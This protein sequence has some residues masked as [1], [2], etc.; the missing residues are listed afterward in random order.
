[1]T[2]T[3][4]DGPRKVCFMVMPYGKRVTGV[5]AP[6]APKEV[7][8]DRLW[9][10]AYRP[11]LLK[12]GY[13]PVRADMDLGALIIKEMLERFVI[14]H[15]VCADISIPN[16]NVYYEIGVRHAAQEKG[17]VM[18]AADWA[19]P[20]FDIAQ[21]PR[22]VYP[23]ADGSV[24][25]SCVTEVHDL[26]VDHF[27][28]LADGTSP[29]Y[30]AVTGY[31]NAQLDSAEAFKAFVRQL[32]TIQ[33]KMRAIRSAAPTRRAQMALALAETAAKGGE[34]PPSV[35]L[36]LLFLL[37]DVAGWQET[38]KYIEKLP[39]EMRDIPVVLE[40]LALA[41]SKSRSH[42][43]AVSGLETLIQLS[44]ETSERRGLLGGRF[45]KLMQ[46]AESTD[47]RFHYLNRA[48]ENYQ[49]GTNLDLNDYYPSSNLP[50]L[51][52]AWGRDE[53]EKLA[54]AAAT[55]ALAAVHRA[56]AL[57]PDDKWIRPTLLGAAFDDGNVR[58]A[59]KLCSE[60]RREGA[61]KWKLA[62]TLSDLKQAIDL[63]DDE[64]VQG[65]LRGVFDDL[66]RL[67]P[68]K[69]HT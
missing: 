39:A 9:E 54:Q 48:I 44:G 51:Y 5:D 1:M 58:E 28:T 47:D 56:R 22:L 57:H 34:T 69:F 32:S 40:Q 26:I 55:I 60:I 63:L 14:A 10:E 25:D 53:D 19:K 36:E 33:G 45:K 13:E 27:Q 38:K 46:D 66:A 59:K 68:D 61:D 20:L 15:L 62:T 37:R 6:N 42:D 43:E 29:V 7:D 17:C 49:L 35:S 31:P 11:A 50:R 16:G 18:L 52:R 67:V 3:L 12:L 65:E 23:L 30:Q 2:T 4:G 21:M 64:S 8:F 41:Q 24:P